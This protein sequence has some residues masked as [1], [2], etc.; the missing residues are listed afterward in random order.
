MI[1]LLLQLTIS[2]LIV[3]W[4]VNE[5]EALSTFSHTTVIMTEHLLLLVFQTLNQ[6]NSEH[7]A[8]ACYASVLQASPFYKRK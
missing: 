8:A 4:C 2:Y 3:F 5:K 6:K 7:L 1:L